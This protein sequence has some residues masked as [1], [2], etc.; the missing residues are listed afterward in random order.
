MS[1]LP[2]QPDAAPP[3]DPYAAWRCRNYQ[4]YAL[5]WFLM[6]FAKQAE[7]VV[8]GMFVYQ[9]TQT[10]LSLA[11]LGLVQAAPIILLSIAGGQLADRVNRKAIL[12]VAVLLNAGV[13]VG[14]V[15]VA[16]W[17]LPISWIYG[18]VFVEA[19]VQALGMP[20][21]AALLPQIVPGPTFSNA[22]T[23]NSS[24]FQVATMTGPAVAGL[25]LGFV[26]PAAAFAMVGVCRLLSAAVIAGVRT[27]PFV[28][29]EEAV[30]WSSVLAGLR[31]V[32]RNKPI[33]ATITLDLFAVLLGGATYLLPVFAEDILGVGAVGLGFL[34]S[35]E[36]LGAISMAF[37]L[38]HLP[39]MKRAGVT[40]L[41]AV[42]GFGAWTMVF[43]L[44]TWYPLSLLAIFLIGCLD[45]VSVVVRHTLVQML[46]PDAMR[47]RVSAVNGVFIVASN[48]LGGLK[49]GVA[50]WLFGPVLAVVGGGVGAIAIVLGAVRVWPQLLRLGALNEIRP[51]VSDPPVQTSG[52]APLVEPSS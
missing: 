23:W 39:P 15:G 44:S 49:S 17:Q 48:D 5:G 2:C 42:A 11:W 4:L 22:V 32:W 10:A 34:R 26:S 35:A 6:T 36:A 3:V 18:L 45:N 13:S 14:L 8:V 46:T 51:E 1:D 27:E 25:V 28:R 19:I 37:L 12:L 7:T 21:R 38:A 40:M 50:A 24:V 31:F 29:S 41:W 47:G 20:A 43:G 16:G 30:S 52:R 33:L 9:Q